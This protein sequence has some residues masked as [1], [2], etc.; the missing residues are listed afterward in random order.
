MSKTLR[1]SLSSKSTQIH[2][3]LDAWRPWLLDCFGE[4]PENLLQLRFEHSIA[5]LAARRL[6]GS[7]RQTERSPV[8]LKLLDERLRSIEFPPGVLPAMALRCSAISSGSGSWTAEWLDCP[9]A[10]HFSGLCKPVVAFNIPFVDNLSRGSEWREVVIVHRTDAAHLLATLQD[11]FP[12]GPGLK[13]IGGSP[14]AVKPLA[15]EDLVL[16]DSVVRLVQED[17]LLFLQREDWFRKHKLPFRRGYLLHGVP[18]N[19]KSSIIRAML[20]TPGISGLTLNPFETPFDEDRLALMFAEAA[21]STPSLIVLED[22]DRCYPLDKARGKECALPV[23]QL[24]NQLDGVGSQDGIIVVATANDPAVLDPAILRR[25]GR[26]DRVVAIQNPPGPLRERYFRQMHGSLTAEDLAECSLRTEGFSF[27]QLR[28]TYILAGQSALEENCP[29][30]AK[31][32][33]RAA[34]TLVETMM[35]ADRRWKAAAGF[36]KQKAS[37]WPDGPGKLLE[38]SESEV[39]HS[40]NALSSSQERSKPIPPS[41]G[42]KKHPGCGRT[43]PL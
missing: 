27:A 20:S 16:E 25:P 15:W 13:I 32:L 1:L 10:L 42:C 6:L 35:V 14:V 31:M 37:S 17:F 19:G 29:I 41:D 2:T 18:G 9:V 40:N 39:P 4:K 8:S 11:A 7:D 34:Q 26:F 28:E 38:T 43:Q 5:V 22:L 21:Q 3:T 12:T 33:V 23:Q 30:D 36:R 24:M